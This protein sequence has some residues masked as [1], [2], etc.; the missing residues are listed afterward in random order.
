M[1]WLWAHIPFMWNQKTQGR[2][3]PCTITA[4]AANGL[5]D[6]TYSGPVSVQ[7]GGSAPF[8]TW[9]V[10]KGVYSDAACTQVVNGVQVTSGQSQQVYID[11]SQTGQ[12]PGTDGSF[13]DVSAHL[14]GADGTLGNSNNCRLTPSAPLPVTPKPV[15][16]FYAKG[17]GGGVPVFM[18][19]LQPGE[20]ASITVQSGGETVWGGV[21]SN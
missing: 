8:Q 18:D 1:A 4:M 5:T 14:V 19:Q 9:Y 10:L 6:T 12:E 7:T 2:G 15:M 20:V 17:S 3:V 21:V 16:I 13:V 11:F